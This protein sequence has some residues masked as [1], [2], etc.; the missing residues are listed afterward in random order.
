[1]IE[2]NIEK[3]DPLQLSITGS[4]NGI[5]IVGMTTPVY[6]FDLITYELAWKI[7]RIFRVDG[8]GRHVTDS[9]KFKVIDKVFEK[10][11][12]IAN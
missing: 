8:S 9:I 11:C 4:C 3:K 2:I 10:L 6:S 5:Q 7:T 1:M 12:E